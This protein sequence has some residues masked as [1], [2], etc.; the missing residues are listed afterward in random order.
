MPNTKLFSEKPDLIAAI[1]VIILILALI[2]TGLFHAIPPEPL[3]VSVS[4]SIFS[5]ARAMSTVRQIEQKPHP[6]GTSENAR[7]RN[8][9][10][11]ELKALGLETRI[12]TALGI[13]K[14]DQ[15]GSVGVVYN[16]LVRVPGRLPGKALL[17]AAHYDS[18][19][20]GPGAAD[21]GASVAAILETLIALKTLPPLRNDVICIFTDGEEA[22][23]LGAEAFVAEH[24]WAKHIGLVLNFEY[25]AT[26]ALLLCSKPALVMANLLMALQRLLP[27]LWATRSCTRSTSACRM[28]RT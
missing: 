3:P 25:L 21:D 24:P 23:L 18:T 20:T 11:A 28:I 27:I 12:Q 7:V 13:N 17:L 22:G 6:I 16:V 9:L 1:V 14:S 8:Y 19:H 2:I 15:D 5:S 4:A 26:V 10:V